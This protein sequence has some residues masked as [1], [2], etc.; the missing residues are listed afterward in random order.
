MYTANQWGMVEPQKFME[1]PPYMNWCRILMA[2]L[3][4][5]QNHLEDKHWR[6]FLVLEDPYT[7]TRVHNDL[8]PNFQPF[9]THQVDNTTFSPICLDFQMD[10]QDLFE[11]HPWN[12]Y[13]FQDGSHLGNSM[14]N[15]SYSMSC[16]GFIYDE[17]IVGNPSCS[18]KK[19]KGFGPSE[20]TS[21]DLPTLPETNVAPEKGMV[22]IRLFPFGARPIF[23]GCV[24]FREGTSG[25]LCFASPILNW[26]SVSFK[27]SFCQTGRKQAK[28][29]SQNAEI[30]WT[31]HTSSKSQCT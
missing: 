13:Q 4:R 17:R 21:S 19:Y 6:R 28:E 26:R 11:L 24:S 16:Y 10:L 14:T 18:W 27:V 30:C 12:V 2:F 7:K 15:W 31:P 9:L 23:R 25:V 20:K 8:S 3:H 1:H 22:G 29:N 5:P